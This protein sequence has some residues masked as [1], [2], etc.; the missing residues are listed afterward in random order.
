MSQV[1]VTSQ[2]DNSLQTERIKLPLDVFA[3]YG[4]NVITARPEGSRRW[5]IIAKQ[6]LF[7]LQIRKHAER[8]MCDTFCWQY[9]QDKNCPGLVPLISTLKGELVVPLG[10]D[11]VAYLTGWLSGRQAELGLKEDVIRVARCLA[12]IHRLAA[13]MPWPGTIPAD[14]WMG[15]DWVRLYEERRADLAIYHKVATHKLYPVDFDRL[16][17]G[18]YDRMMEAVE[19]SVHLLEKSNLSVRVAGEAT[20]SLSLDSCRGRDFLVS[21]EAQL[22]LGD[23]KDVRRDVYAR[24]LALLLENIGYRSQWSLALGKVAL[25]AYGQVRVIQEEERAV[26]LGLAL[27]PGRLWRL[28]HKWYKG[29]REHSD[30]KYTADLRQEV[31]REPL[32]IAYFHRLV[33]EGCRLENRH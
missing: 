10:K 7:R 1:Q 24:D 22:Y 20:A 6:G 8:V 27:F 21:D 5:I 15:R 18:I 29:K 17:L 11:T 14:V 25:D 33:R 9:L 12:Y 13:D 3:T 26:I 32:R 2:E 30:L 19:E 16:F 4:L 23:L 31:A 28:V